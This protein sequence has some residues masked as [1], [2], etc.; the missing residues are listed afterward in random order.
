[1]PR[2]HLSLL[3]LVAA[4]ILPLQSQAAYKTADALAALPYLDADPGTAQAHVSTEE[5]S[6]G[7]AMLNQG[8][9]VTCGRFA[10]AGV[11]A[12]EQKADLQL[13]SEPFVI[14]LDDGSRLPASAFELTAGPE[15]AAVM[16]SP[17]DGC[18]ARRL[19][20]QQISLKLLSHDGMLAANWRA[21]L[22]D[23]SN[24]IR[25]ELELEVL[26]PE[27]KVGSIEMLSGSGGRLSQAGTATGVPALAG[28]LFLNIEHPSADN[29]AGV[30]WQ[31]I[32]G[33]TPAEMSWPEQ[34]LQSWDLGSA[35]SKPGSYEVW[36]DYSAGGYRLE[37][38]RCAISQGQRELAVDEHFGAT[39]IAQ[40]DNIYELRIDEEQLQAGN[41][42][43]LDVMLR[44][45]G[46]TDSAGNIYLRRLEDQ[47]RL[48]CRLPVGQT[49]GA[50]S[51]LKLS[52]VVGAA[53]AGQLRRA[54]SFY[55]ER[56][57]AH[58]YRPF[59]HYNSWYDIGYFNKY[60]EQDVLD[61]MELYKTELV[62]RRGV[63]FESFLLDD[64]WDNYDSLWDF[65]AG[66]P[67]GFTPLAEKSATYGGG[68]GVWLSPWGGYGEPR[69]R[70]LKASA[71]GGY[72]TNEGGFALSGPKYYARFS[73][74]C[75]QMVRDY[76][77]NM[78]K[79]DGLGEGTSRVPGSP[80]ASDFDAAIHLIGELRETR[81]D[82]FINLTTGTWPS[83]SWVLIADTIYR[84]GWDHELSGE[85]TDRQRWMNYRDGQTYSNIAKSSP[86]FPLNSLMLHG[87]IYAKNARGLKTDPQSDLRSEL[88]SYFAS[89]TQLQELYVTPSLLTEQN[90][91]DLAASALWARQYSL[92][93]QDAH[94]VGGDPAAGQ[95]Y[96]WAGWHPR[97]CYLALRNPS[98]E[99][100]LARL[101][102]GATFELPED[103]CEC[104]ELSSP[105]GDQ[106]VQTLRLAPGQPLL[107]ELRP[108]EVLVL[109][110]C[111]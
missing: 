50:G 110:R 97:Q 61:T 26:A 5:F 101:E 100:R 69:E 22:L 91:D 25:Q 1:M 10:N 48:S 109:C 49:L 60:G 38:N 62:E 56:E 86:L 82:V 54:Y 106:R 92:A 79:F 58:P 21:I 75:Q 93:L 94:W 45:D 24:Y 68:I 46:G 17:D 84:G 76:N 6:L 87:V 20:G 42:C 70:R 52:C 34:H 9:S 67:H 44:A 43:R 89:G 39:G 33:W 4:M 81:S 57:R 88:R 80:F 16:P 15:L 111:E 32:A 78:F 30:P 90:W 53:P 19:P 11:N 105:Y 73:Q 77:V 99:S 83:P 37:V 18:L 31:Q 66:F 107:L 103:C 104:I 64:G 28:P 23:G 12:V 29:S 71:P 74:I 65:H 36:F 47:P 8:W 27:L 2:L 7:N 63:P 40:I 51:R 85:G 95:A 102:A 59:L 41:P 13:D 3:A 35:I 55:L 14:L 98:K 108:F 72:E 96:G